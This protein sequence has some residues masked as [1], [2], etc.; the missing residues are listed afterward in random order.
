MH[1]SRAAG[2]NRRRLKLSHDD[3]E[4]ADGKRATKPMEITANLI[5]SG[6]PFGPK[7]GPK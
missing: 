5:A 4:A 7:F 1:C 3:A 2:S 6:L